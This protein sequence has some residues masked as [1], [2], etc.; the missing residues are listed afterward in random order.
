M[1]T[2]APLKVSAALFCVLN[3]LSV[4]AANSQTM[5]L[6]F[7]PETKQ[8]VTE[9]GKGKIKL[10]TL[11]SIES[12]EQKKQELAA[13]ENRLDAKLKT[14]DDKLKQLEK[15][16]STPPVA[17]AAPEKTLPVVSEKPPAQ[18]GEEKKVRTNQI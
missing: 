10:N 16:E 4:T 15:L 12:L 3:S 13:I 2:P 14:L 1:I 6:Y 8:I 18:A 11:Q 5:E 7:D 17:V 9:P